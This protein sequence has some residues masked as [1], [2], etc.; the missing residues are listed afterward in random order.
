MGRIVGKLI[1]LALALALVFLALLL[2]YRFA[3]APSTLML[4]RWLT[5][6]SVERDWVPAGDGLVIE[7][8]AL[9][10]GAADE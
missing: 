4:G 8:W 9:S 5:F 3:P 7:E 1:R 6:R 2:L 10:P